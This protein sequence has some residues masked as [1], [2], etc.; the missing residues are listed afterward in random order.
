MTGRIRR[1]YN[2]E[3]RRLALV[4]IIAA[5][6]AACGN[7]FIGPVDHRCPTNPAWNGSGCGEY[8]RSR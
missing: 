1:G 2:N 6:L 5:A 8:G 3:M 4:L 7:A